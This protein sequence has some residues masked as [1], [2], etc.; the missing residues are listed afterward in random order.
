MSK[1]D[2]G[3]ALVDEGPIHKLVSKVMRD[4]LMKNY[5]EGYC[6]KVVSGIVFCNPSK[7][8]VVT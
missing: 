2:S 8:M 1:P 4:E 5:W 7:V 6:K 3:V